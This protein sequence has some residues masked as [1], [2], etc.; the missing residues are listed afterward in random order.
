MIITPKEFK[1]LSKYLQFLK[2]ELRLPEWDVYVIAE[3]PDHKTAYAEVTPTEGRKVATIAFS[4]QI[5]GLEHEEIRRIC[6]HE[7]LHL[8]HRDVSQMF[9]GIETNLGD[10]VYGAVVSYMRLNCEVMVD[11][12]TFAFAALLAESGRDQKYLRKIKPESSGR[13]AIE[14]KEM[15]TDA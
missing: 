11:Q 1:A 9:Y 2:W 14:Y 15:K 3:P 4:P 8:H 6:I 10:H 13:K 12:L 5:M 7:L